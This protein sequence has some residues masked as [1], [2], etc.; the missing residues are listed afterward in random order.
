MKV[1][2]MGAISNSQ[3]PPILLKAQELR[4]ERDYA[5]VVA[6]GDVELSDGENFVYADTITYNQKTKIVTAT[7]NVQLFYKNGSVISAN[8]LEIEDTLKEGFIEK[9]YLYTQDKARFAGNRSEIHGNITTIS[10]GVYTPCKMCKNEDPTW[11]I[12]ATQVERDLNQ[13]TVT[14]KN[15]RL[16]FLGCPVFYAPYFSHVDPSIKRRSGF[17][18]PLLGYGGVFGAV[19]GVPYYWDLGPDQD[20]TLMPIVTTKTG[21]FLLGEYRKRFRTGILQFTGSGGYTDT[22]TNRRNTLKHHPKSLHGHVAGSAEFHLNE[23]WRLKAQLQRESNQTYLRR[24]PFLDKKGLGTQ[25]MLVSKGNLE[26]FYDKNYASLKAYWFQDLQLGANLKETPLV[27]PV[28]R[29][30]YVGDPGRCGDFWE[31]DSGGVL[32]TRREGVNMGRLSSKVSWN[33]PY[34]SSLGSILEGRLSLRGDIYDIQRYPASLIL[35]RHHL[36]IGRVLPRAY[37]GFRHPFIATFSRNSM[38]IEPIINLVIGPYIPNSTKI[39]N[40]D[41]QDFEFTAENLFQEDRFSGLDLIDTGQRINYGL[42]AFFTSRTHLK[43]DALF[44]QSYSFS[45]IDAFTKSGIRKGASD[46]VGRFKISPLTNYSLAYSF[47]LD[48]KNLNLRFSRSSLTVGPPIFRVGGHY[49]YTTDS[50]LGGKLPVQH[51]LMTTF[52]SEFAENWKVSA[53]LSYSFSRKPGALE[54]G[55]VLGYHNDC[56]GAE[57]LYRRSYYRDRDV[58]PS[59]LYFLRFTFKNLGTFTT[60]PIFRDESSAIMPPEDQE[61]SKVGEG[62]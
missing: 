31:I 21:A 20:A 41:S 55:G 2:W 62:R 48:Q 8:Y 24:F 17:L 46:Y 5:L 3:K 39:P 9:V 1:A 58:R 14:Y 54:H 23:Q 26:G 15:A 25:N 38:V 51:Q 11:Q 40:E 6:T 59:S 44:G 28:L 35:R 53:D 10:E 43:A 32:I 13:G 36:S 45:K 30:H 47:R 42:R 27:A 16:E 12:K 33:L 50:Y 34:L 61:Q 52:S 19:G 57:L 7:G 37:L 18:S 60:S 56:F 29:Y 22:T 49:I 4:H